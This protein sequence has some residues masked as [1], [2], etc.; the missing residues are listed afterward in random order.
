MI[1]CIW[2]ASSEKGAYGNFKIFL[3]GSFQLSITMKVFI[4]FALIPLKRKC[5][6]ILKKRPSRML[7]ISNCDVIY[8]VIYVIC[9]HYVWKAISPLFPWPS[10]Y[11]SIESAQNSS[12]TMEKIRLNSWE[13]L[14]QYFLLTCC[15]V[16][17]VIVWEIGRWKRAAGQS[18]ATGRVMWMKCLPRD[19]VQPMEAALRIQMKSSV[20]TENYVCRNMRKFSENP[21]LVIFLCSQV[22]KEIYSIA[23]VILSVSS[24]DFTLWPCT[25]AR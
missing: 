12:N 5:N 11:V 10:S 25:G 21:D 19:T 6:S 18:H 3:W 20:N 15:I 16:V 7:H 14:T 9:W 4:D 2:A 1:I 23:S 24:Y 22:V 8:Y 17:N 13:N